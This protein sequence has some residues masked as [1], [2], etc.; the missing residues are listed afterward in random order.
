MRDWRL[1]RPDALEP[2]HTLGGSYTSRLLTGGVYRGE[3]IIN[4]NEGTLQG[5]G[6]TPG[7]VHD[8]LEIYYIVRCQEGAQVVLE[9]QEEGTVHFQV[10]PGDTIIIPPQTRHWIDNTQCQ[11]EMVILTFWQRQEDNITYHRRMEAWGVSQRF[12]GDG[13]PGGK[14]ALF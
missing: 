8:K 4:I 3:D 9:S 6:R 12:R 14:D 5:G 2:Y 1:V 11:E 7:D 13:E 10:R